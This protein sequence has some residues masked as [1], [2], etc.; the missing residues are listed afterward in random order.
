MEQG[1]L[2]IRSAIPNE[3]DFFEEGLVVLPKMN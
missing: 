1:T 2:T 3:L